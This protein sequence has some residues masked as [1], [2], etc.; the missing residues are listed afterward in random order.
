MFVSGNSNRVSLH[1][2]GCQFIQGD[3][4][5]KAASVMRASYNPRKYNLQGGGNSCDLIAIPTISI[6][7]LP[8]TARDLLPCKSYTL[9]VGVRECG[10]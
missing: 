7:F 4:G 6:L 8:P 9:Y 3:V 10:R 2:A 1:P 5:R